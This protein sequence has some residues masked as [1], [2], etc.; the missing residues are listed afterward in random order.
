MSFLSNGLVLVKYLPVGVWFGFLGGE[1]EIVNESGETPKT[2]VVHR[3][4][5]FIGDVAQLIGG[6]ALVSAAA[7]TDREVYEVS[8]E[9]LREILD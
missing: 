9:A 8:T 7:R 5:E 4:G 6:P 1:V 2:V 3:P